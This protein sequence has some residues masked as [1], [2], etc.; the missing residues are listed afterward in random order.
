MKGWNSGLSFNFGQFP[1]SWIRIR[2]PKTDPRYHR[3]YRTIW[4]LPTVQYSSYIAYF[5]TVDEKKHP[6]TLM[7]GERTPMLHFFLFLL[8]LQLPA[9][10]YMMVKKIFCLL[11]NAQRAFVL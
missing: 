7:L 10:F 2:I 5:R 8:L 9:L 4:Y 1:C 11:T 6:I 3:Q